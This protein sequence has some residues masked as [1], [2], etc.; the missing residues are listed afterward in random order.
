MRTK[1]DVRVTLEN[2][3]TS[4]ELAEVKVIYKNR[5]REKVKV[6]SSRDAYQIFYQIFD[7][8]TI[9]Y[10]EQFYMLLLNR[11][12][13]VLGWIKLSHGGMSGTIVD[14]KV[15]FSIALMT[16]CTCIVLC[17]NHP[18]GSTIPSEADIALTKSLS[19]SGK[20]LEISLLDHLI[21]GQEGCY[22]SFAD[23]GR[24]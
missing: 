18:S 10:Q 16:S 3:V 22:Y 13:L 20:L 19:Q 21:I 7:K 23:E 8:D 24:L 17:H 15:V 12:N 14:P 6:C 5:Q 4:P 2:F 11:A 9:E 1:N